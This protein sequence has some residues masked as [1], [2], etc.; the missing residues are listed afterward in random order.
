M[1]LPGISLASVAEFAE[2]TLCTLGCV[3]SPIQGAF[4]PFSLKTHLN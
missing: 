2:A 4:T 3:I 1:L